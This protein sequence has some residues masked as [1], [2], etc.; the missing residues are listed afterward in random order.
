M[1]YIMHRLEAHVSVA[2][3]SQEGVVRV[4]LD[5]LLDA[6]LGLQDELAVHVAQNQL[7]EDEHQEQRERQRQTRGFVVQFLLDPRDHCA[8][9]N[10]HV[11]RLPLWGFLLQLVVTELEIES[12][13]R[14]VLVLKTR[15]RIQTLCL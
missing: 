1:G 12:D 2:G 10:A 3:A 14:G 11:Q 5:V 15:L 9:G 6:L 13:E 4:L 8:L 7:A